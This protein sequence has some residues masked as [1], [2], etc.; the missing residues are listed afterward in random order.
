M[1]I[2][3][4]G[5]KISILDEMD[6]EMKVSKIGQQYDVDQRVEDSSS[7]FHKSSY[8]FQS[9]MEPHGHNWRKQAWRLQK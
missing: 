4:K 2:E 7:Y 3:A 9:R 1:K 5:R 6:L 8:V